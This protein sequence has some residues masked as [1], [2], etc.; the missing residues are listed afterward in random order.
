MIPF[1]SDCPLCF[2]FPLSFDGPSVDGSGSLL[3]LVCSSVCDVLGLTDDNDVTSGICVVVVAVVVTGL[4]TK[5]TLIILDLKQLMILRGHE[6]SVCASFGRFLA[7]LF[8]TYQVN[9]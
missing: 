1:L 7:P 6:N 3:V 9:P 2:F 4:K 8:E 5:A